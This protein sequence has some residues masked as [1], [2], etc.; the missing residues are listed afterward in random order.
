M[1]KDEIKRYA[2]FGKRSPIPGASFISM[3][4]GIYD[5][6][7]ELLS[8]PNK[9]PLVDYLSKIHWRERLIP[10]IFDRDEM[11]E[12]VAELEEILIASNYAAFKKAWKAYETLAIENNIDKSV[13]GEFVQAL[14]QCNE[15]LCYEAERAIQ[16][17]KGL[18]EGDDSPRTCFLAGFHYARAMALK[19]APE[20]YLGAKMKDGFKHSPHTGKKKNP[21]KEPLLKAWKKFLKS[22]QRKDIQP[23]EVKDADFFNWIVA[24]SRQ[25]LRDNLGIEIRY[26]YDKC[27]YTGKKN[28]EKLVSESSLRSYLRDFRKMGHGNKR[29]VQKGKKP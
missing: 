2:E 17:F 27:K 28:G 12:K 23:W 13:E 25:P 11:L 19:K 3:D 18:A 1:K 8:F 29:Y 20:A 10:N 5:Y 16:F 4:D 24:S 7:L 14:S 6:P 22:Q 26:D 21:L 15:P 9:P